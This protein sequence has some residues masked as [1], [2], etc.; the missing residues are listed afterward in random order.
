MLNKM[1]IKIL[2]NL[3]KILSLSIAL[4]ACSTYP[5]RFK[6]GDARGLGC[7]MVREIDVKIDSGEVEAPY[8]KTKKNCKN[9]KNLPVVGLEPASTSKSKVTIEEKTT[10]ETD[11]NTISF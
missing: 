3:L 1:P 10:E 2:S 9:C 6:C 8:Q 7:T 5:A 11:D 4:T